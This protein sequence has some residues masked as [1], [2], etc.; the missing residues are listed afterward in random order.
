MTR[1]CENCKK[2]VNLI[3]FECKCEY[4][5]LCI[6]CKMPEYHKCQSLEEFKKDAK[7]VLNKNNPVV[8]SDK[9]IKI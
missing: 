1:R 8:V 9:L 2:K 7:E 6:N 3:Y 4:K 5:T